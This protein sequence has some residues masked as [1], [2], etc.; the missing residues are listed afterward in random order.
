MTS[1]SWAI[2]LGSHSGAE[3]MYRRLSEGF[4]ATGLRILECVPYG[5]AI[6]MAI[7][8]RNECRKRLD[9]FIIILVKI[10]SVPLLNETRVGH[11]N[12]M[13][14]EQWEKIKLCQIL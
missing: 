13:T 3:A 1:V 9:L 2:G 7:K 8:S 10:V 14:K 4:C 12:R 11:T 5:V 6:M